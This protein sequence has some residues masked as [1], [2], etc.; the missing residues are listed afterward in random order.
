MR[1][2]G[3]NRGEQAVVVLMGVG[4]FQASVFV[5]RRG[6]RLAGTA[7]GDRVFVP[8]DFGL[9]GNDAGLVRKNR[10]LCSFQNR[11]R[12]KV[13]VAPAKVII[14]LRKM[15]G[16][17][18]LAVSCHRSPF[19]FPV[20]EV[21]RNRRTTGAC[22]L[23]Q[24][25]LRPEHASCFFSPYP[26]PRHQPLPVREALPHVANRSSSGRGGVQRPRPR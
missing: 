3:A 6:R 4:L 1:Q 19:R 13:V 22:A 25:A 18:L 20:F 8:R 2:E 14:G 10:S 17:G 24:N 15:L 23:W 5:G 11:K 7:T 26:Q 21:P 12:F 9:M 16:M